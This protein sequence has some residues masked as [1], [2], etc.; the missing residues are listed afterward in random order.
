VAD[1]SEQ[2]KLRVILALARFELPSD[3][4]RELGKEGIE[5]D[6]RQICGYDPTKSYYEAGDK[7]RAIF[8]EERE[9]YMVEVQSVPIANQGWRL[10]MLQRVFDQAMVTKNRVLATATLRQAAEEVGGALT[11]ERVNHNKSSISEATDDERR[12]MAADLVA[13]LASQFDPKSA[14][15]AP[16]TVQ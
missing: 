2:T 13:R 10:Q 9:R 1:F 16:K 3:V 4:A 6:A 7:W 14:V 8:N 11:N 5:T 15:E 12:A